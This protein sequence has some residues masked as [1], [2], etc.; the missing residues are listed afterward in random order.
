MIFIVI[1]PFMMDSEEKMFDLL[2]EEILNIIKTFKCTVCGC[3]GNGC[4]TFKDIYRVC[5]TYRFVLRSSGTKV[6]L[7]TY[8]YTNQNGHD[9]QLL[10][11][12]CFNPDF[13]PCP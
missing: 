10:P 7:Y 8:N 3:A 1:I 5:I 12:G 11:G 13:R 9:I 4:Y 6:F 2:P